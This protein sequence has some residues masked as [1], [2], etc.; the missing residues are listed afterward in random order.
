MKKV[1]TTLLFLYSLSLWSYICCE[2]SGA[3]VHKSNN[4]S[5]DQGAVALSD[6]N[7]LLVWSDAVSEWQQVK[8][9][10]INPEGENIW[11]EPV[12][13]KSD[14]CKY[15]ICIT[16]Q[17][18]A[19]GV[20]V[21]WFDG[22]EIIIQKLDLS[23]NKLWGENGINI[24]TASQYDTNDIIWIIEGENGNAYIAWHI[25]N[26]P[27]ELDAVCLDSAGNFCPGWSETGNVLMS[28]STEMGYSVISDGYGGLIAYYIDYSYAL[29]QRYQSN[30][31]SLWGED[32]I[33]HPFVFWGMQMY[34]N[35]PGEYHIIYKYEDDFC[36]TGLNENGELLFEEPADLF[37][38]PEEAGYKYDIDVTSD[39]NYAILWQEDNLIKA[40]KVEA[41]GNILW[42]E[43]G[44]I[45]GDNYMNY[46]IFT[47]TSDNS[48]GIYVSWNNDE[49][50]NNSYTFERVNSAGE[51]LIGED[52]YDVSVSD[53]SFFKK[54]ICIQADDSAGIFWFTDDDE[55]DIIRMQSV[56]STGE[57]L[58]EVE[59]RDLYALHKL[60]CDPTEMA[61][62]EHYTAVVWNLFRSDRREIRCQILENE[63]GNALLPEYGLVLMSEADLRYSVIDIAFDASEELLYAAFNV[64]TTDNIECNPG[65]Q[66][67]DMAGNKLY[68]DEGLLMCDWE[69]GS[70][71][72]HMI[73]K[74][75]ADGMRLLWNEPCPDVPEL[76]V[77]NM[78]KLND[79]GFA[80][81]EPAIICG[82]T[83]SGNAPVV[84]SGD[85]L[86]WRYGE[87]IRVVKFDEMGEVAPGWNGSYLQ[88]AQI[89]ELYRINVHETD[90]GIIII[91]ESDDLGTNNYYGYLFSEEGEYLW[92]AEGRHLFETDSF[93]YLCLNDD[94]FYV[95]R[96]G[97]W[98]Y[99]RILDRYNYE[100][101]MLW[102]T[103]L[104]WLEY[105]DV[106]KTL[107]NIRDDKIFLY[108]SLSFENS[109]GM[110][111]VFRGYN[112]DS[113][114]VEGF[115]VEGLTICDEYSGQEL[116]E[117]VTSES[118]KSIV[119]W[120]DSRSSGYSSSSHSI[121]AQKIDLT[122]LGE[123]DNEIISPRIIYNYPNPFRQFT[124]FEILA[125][126]LREAGVIDIYNIKG[127]KVKTLELSRDENFWDGTNA[128]QET[129][130]SGI[131]FYHLRQGVAERS[132][133]KMTLIK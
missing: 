83:L 69:N 82:A 1:I 18:V 131:Y 39:E 6:G 62:S 126:S 96:S 121:Y 122:L 52:G 72:E 90:T 98:S 34:V 114:P 92:G 47:A 75:E 93:P 128:K 95:E 88:T 40:Q 86:V 48:G 15:P 25:F 110:D 113:S 4:L 24:E 76:A 57:L 44:V 78:Q 33:E 120:E 97:E 14:I 125:E 118:G 108:S 32:G 59:G 106:D 115:P 89:E 38:L 123:D 107:M 13:L 8:A 117:V 9:L 100:G 67:I 22:G 94:C 58:L 16:S 73:F 2:D 46:S 7:F 49:I 81:A 10:K 68:G 60:A 11:V 66:A 23:G 30:G 56:S 91:G 27:Q 21:S 20:I 124:S 37:T 36:L 101:E 80:W 61:C 109:N 74:P 87:M 19:G 28:S 54:C 133:G 63:N 84:L 103:S 65:I 129:V 43:G 31:E 132:S 53:G 130:G 3:L 111:L 5:W 35:A 42:Q 26:W 119:L 85:Y 71:Y 79:Q 55:D 116:L 29:F 77:W 12:H 45:V 99:Q 112:S 64:T 102:N 17:E 70:E 50:F 104:M 41:G 105:G 51:T 127:Q